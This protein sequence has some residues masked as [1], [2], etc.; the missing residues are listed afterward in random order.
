MRLS[1]KQA[2]VM[3]DVMKASLH[4]PG[5]FGG[6]PHHVREG[7]VHAVINQQSSELFDLIPGQEL[8]WDWDDLENEEKE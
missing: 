1:F 8:E 2:L 4:I 3:L 7:V 5:A 6:Y